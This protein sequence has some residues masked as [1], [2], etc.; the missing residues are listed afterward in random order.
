MN[1]ISSSLLKY[2]DLAKF[3]LQLQKIPF[4]SLN[5]AVTYI[6]NKFNVETREL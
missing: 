6:L 2:S 5:M 1:S 4:K 3:T